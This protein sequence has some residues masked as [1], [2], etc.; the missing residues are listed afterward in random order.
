MSLILDSSATLAWI[1][2]DE[3]LAHIDKIFDHITVKGCLVPS[4]WHVEVA[5]ALTVAVRR[6]R[7]L[8]LE[9]DEALKDLSFFNIRSAQ[10]TER[11][12][13]SATISIANR[14]NLTIYD[15]AYLELAERAR[16][17]LATLDQELVRAAKKLG[18]TILI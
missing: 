15:A 10:E 5:N 14:L 16:L 3:N 1:L 8:R 9:R 4:L 18:V 12:A 13:W 2:I 6:R 11:H 7:I 17:P